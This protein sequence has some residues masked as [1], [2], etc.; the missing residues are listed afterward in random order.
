M[1]HV[2]YFFAPLT[3]LHC[4]SRFGER[5]AEL[6]TTGFYT[7]PETF[8]VRPGDLFELL[9]EDLETGYLM[10]RHPGEVRD[11]H[12][13]EQWVCP[14]CRLA[15]WAR[16]DLHLDPPERCSFVA[17]EAV[18]LTPDTVRGMHFIHRD[19]KQWASLEPEERDDDQDLGWL[20]TI[21]AGIQ[22]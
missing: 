6:Y 11:I 15:Q 19:M 13:L 18:P 5:D 17:A 22:H 12:A 2:V 16:I 7:G 21:L 4:G 1:P 10:L 3:C 20:Y 8:G 9:F 14:A